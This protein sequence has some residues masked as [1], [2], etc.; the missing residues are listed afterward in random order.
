MSPLL[1]PRQL[2]VRVSGRAEAMVH[3]TCT[4]LLSSSPWQAFVKLDF[5]NAFN[6]VRRDSMLETVA[7]DLPELFNYESSSYASTSSLRFGDYILSSK[8]GVQQGDLLGPLLFSLTLSKALS[9]SRCDLT[10][11]YLDDVTLGDSID[12]LGGEVVDFQ[13][14][15]SSIGLTLN[16]KKCGIV[17][18][19]RVSRNIW[20]MTDFA[21][22]FLEPSMETANLLGAPLF[23]EGLYTYLGQQRKTLQILIQRL[24]LM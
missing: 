22:F 4:F 13:G 5:I 16:V 21:K 10:V 9:L 12:S 11:A 14:C 23:S 2:G 6:T 17:G 8:E 24:L 3:A 15:E 7:L 20:E 18:L 19:N 1:A